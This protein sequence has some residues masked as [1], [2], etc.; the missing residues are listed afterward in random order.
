MLQALLKN[1]L[2]KKG[3]KTLAKALTAFIVA[4][5]L[6]TV[7]VTVDVDVFEASVV[8][9]IIAGLDMARSWAKHKFNLKF[10]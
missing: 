6:D 7:G 8:S 1:I 10:L 5:N 4:S 3:A 2:V 9:G